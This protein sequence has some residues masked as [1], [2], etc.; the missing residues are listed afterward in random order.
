MPHLMLE[1]SN[2]LPEPL[3]HQALFAAL[4]AALERFDGVRLAEIKSRAVAH[5]HYRIG[6][7]TPENVFVHL[8]VAVLSGRELSLRRELSAELLAVLLQAFRRTCQ[9][10]PC[11]VTVDIREMQRETYGKAMSAHAEGPASEL[12]T[13]PGAP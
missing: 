5:D 13:G 6:S 3:D 8:T 7:G 10:R 9:E 4:H 11:D 12:W 2:N 1:Y